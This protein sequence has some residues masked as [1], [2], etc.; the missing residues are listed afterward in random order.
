M[1]AFQRHHN[2]AIKRMHRMSK[3]NIGGLRAVMVE[4]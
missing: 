3:Y 4:S 1:M 2:G